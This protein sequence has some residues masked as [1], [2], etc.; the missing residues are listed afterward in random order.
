MAQTVIRLVLLPLGRCSLVNGLPFPT[1]RDCFLGLGCLLSSA[2]QGSLLEELFLSLRLCFALEPLALLGLCLSSGP[3]L[4]TAFYL[5]HPQILVQGGQWE[6]DSGANKGCD[7]PRVT[8]HLSDRD[9]QDVPY[10]RC[11]SPRPH[12]LSLGTFLPL[13]HPPLRV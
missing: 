7:C 8:W 3:F 9:S 1:L 11:Y 10:L 2:L 4:T 13:A 6:D 12:S 5:C